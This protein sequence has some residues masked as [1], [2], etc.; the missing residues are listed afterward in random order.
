MN[1][2]VGDHRSSDESDIE[3]E[4]LSKLLEKACQELSLTPGEIE[5]SLVDDTTIK[6]L[7]NQY[8][9]KNMPTNVLSFPHYK[10]IS[11]GICADR[12]MFDA[13]NDQPVLWGEVVVCCETVKREAKDISMDFAPELYRI[14]IHG[15]LHLF[16]YTHDTDA[17]YEIM[18]E[19]ELSAINFYN[20]EMKA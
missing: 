7:N 14:C 8:R 9:N 15:I 1:V 10:W 16:G 17:D 2:T 11:P 5:I 18:K 6:N 13:G 12:I 20:K 19:K 4:S 3:P